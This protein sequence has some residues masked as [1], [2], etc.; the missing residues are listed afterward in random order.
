[1]FKRAIPILDKPTESFFLWGP[2]QSGK[3][4]LLK[5]RF[6][7]AEWIDLLKTD[8][9]LD[10]LER[11]FLLREQLLS[12][13]DK[14]LVVIDE[15]QKVPLLLDEVH[16]LI[17]NTKTVFCLCGS[18]ARKVRREHANLLGGR[19]ISYQM[20]GLTSYEMAVSFNLIQSL[21]AGYLP[22]HYLHATPEL[23]IRSYVNDY[24][25]EEIAAE[26]LVRNLPIFAHFLSI[27]ALM[28]TELVNY[29]NIARDCGLSVPA[30]KGYFQ[31]LVDTLMGSFLEPYTNRLKRRLIKSPKFYFFDVGVVNHLAK[32][33][34]LEMGS[35][36][37]GKALE[38]FIFHELLS[39]SHYSQKFYELT[40]WRTSSGLEVDFVIDHFDSAIEVK[41]S[42]KIHQNHLNG[43]RE[44]SKDY[45][46]KKRILVCLEKKPR[47]TEDGILILPVD[48]FCKQLWA[49]QLL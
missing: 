48:L 23:K 30:I 43:L 39:Y 1:M 26:A 13:K 12:N 17:E 28:D 5:Q 35:E 11:P 20:F 44:A 2:R 14:K 18:S 8:E 42:S 32:R 16:W 33:G 25:K 9:Y 46:I 29:S 34:K 36:L 10:Y 31:I 38:N 49:G 37:F 4:T 40:Y 3:T 47:L 24:L 15:I 21:N 41:S 6:P 45:P 22:S 27:A 19:A 7:Q